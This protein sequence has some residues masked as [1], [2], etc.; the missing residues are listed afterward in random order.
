MQ[1]HII[2]HISII[3]F[4]RGIYLEV[5]RAIHMFMKQN[6]QLSSY[7]NDQLSSYEIDNFQVQGPK[8][9]LEAESLSIW[10][11]IL[12]LFKYCHYDHLLFLFFIFSS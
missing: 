7:E 5:F 3:Y 4:Y 12:A 2:S 9:H 6:D 8:L 11:E 1:R 10:K